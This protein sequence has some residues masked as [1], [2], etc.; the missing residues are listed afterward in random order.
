MYVWVLQL[1]GIYWPAERLQGRLF[2]VEYIYCVCVCVSE[3][4]C[5]CVSMCV[6]V[7]VHNTYFPQYREVG[8]ARE[9]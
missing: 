3:C 5:V 8:R 4:V 7:C 1:Q 2:N 9:K 6:C